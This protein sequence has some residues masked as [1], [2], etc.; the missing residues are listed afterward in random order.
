MDVK[1]QLLATAAII[2]ALALSP[3]TVSATNAAS[4]FDPV[5]QS[6]GI[7]LATDH[8]LPSDLD[9]TS[10]VVTDAEVADAGPSTDEA[11]VS[12]P[13][14]IVV[15]DDKVQCPN[16]QFTSIQAA[17]LAANP[18]DRIL[19]CPGNY[20]EN[21]KV[22]K[23]LTIVGVHPG[24]WTNH[25]QAPTVP[26]PTQ[27]AILH[28]PPL[29]QLNPYIGFD[30]LADNITIGGFFIEPQLQDGLQAAGIVSR[31]TFSG[32]HILDNVFQ[33]NSQG[34]YPGSTGVFPTQVNHNCFRDNNHGG[35]A[36]GNGIYTDIGL[37]NATI[38]DNYFTL[39]QNGAIVIDTFLAKPSGL[40]ITRNASVDDSSIALFHVQNSTVSKNFSLR[41]AG[42]AIY[43]GGDT[44]N[45]QIKQNR[46]QDGSFNGISIHDDTSFPAA[47]NTNLLVE[48]NKISGFGL[49]GIRIQGVGNT[50]VVQ[51]NRSEDNVQD[52]LHAAGG[53]NDLPETS[54]NFL[55]K[56][57]MMRFNSSFDC[58]DGNVPTLNQ[59]VENKGF[60]QNQSGLCKH[61]D[62]AE[63]QENEDQENESE[64]AD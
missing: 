38:A 32:F 57:N 10:L 54:A 14:T 46:L 37:I 28:Y 24:G 41:S 56:R 51:Y 47:P 27:V 50:N 7:P 6:L 35:A 52:G 9:P 64:A 33:H 16:A 49:N 55:I 25:C 61:G 34:A 5:T 44:S 58:Y 40:T 60:T 8:F 30:L 62:D 15:D 11:L 39:D 26:N 29:G 63:S 12:Q 4:I 23:S 19:V 3:A 22:P 13:A 31:Q 21:V 2:G 36:S 59:W 18:G 1:R 48:R 43:V 20:V 42:S 45:L 53:A 17:V